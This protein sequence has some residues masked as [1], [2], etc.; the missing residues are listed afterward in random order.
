MT[1]RAIP[2]TLRKDSL[3]SRLFS[4]TNR[5]NNHAG[6]KKIINTIETRFSYLDWSDRIGLQS[7]WSLEEKGW[8]VKVEYKNTP[9]GAGP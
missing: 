9:Y 2:R 3:S 8:H 5:N 1:S 4:S 6:D 7:T